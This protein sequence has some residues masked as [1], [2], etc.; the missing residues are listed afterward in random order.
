MDK[1]KAKAY[2]YIRF[3]SPDQA[4][5]DSYRR[6]RKAAED[7]C[8]D[9]DLEFVDSKEYLFFDKGKSAYKG[10]HLDDTGELAR[11]LRFVKDGTVPTGSY[12]LIENLDRLSR[13]KLR[14]ALPR[15]LDL[16][17]SQIKVAT[18]SDGRCYDENYN[19]LDLIIS[20]VQMS[21]AHDESF[22][23]SQRVHQAW[24]KKQDKA[25]ADK[26]PLGAACPSWLTVQD[27]QYVPIPERVEVVRKIFNL[28]KEGYGQRLICNKLNDE[29]VPVFGTDKRN[30]SGKWGTS[31]IN[32]I[33]NNKA[34]IGEYQPTNL[35]EGVRKPVGEPVKD[36]FP[37]VVDEELWYSAHSERQQRAIHKTTKPAKI[38]N[39]WQGIIKCANCGNAYHLINKGE[40]SRGGRYLRCFGTTKREC[41]TPLIRWDV[42]ELVFKELLTKVDSLPL[43]KDSTGAIQQQLTVVDGKLTEVNERL[44][45]IKD[46]MLSLGG[47]MPAA[48]VEVLV[49]L[50]EQQ[51]EL[52]QQKNS[53]YQEMQREKIIDKDEFLN[54]VDLVSYEGRFKANRL[55]KHLGVNVSV[56][57]MK[58]R[59]IFVVF[60][61]GEKP[62]LLIHYDK[63]RGIHIGPMGTDMMKLCMDQGDF[64]AF[65]RAK[66]DSPEEKWPALKRSLSKAYFEG[67]AEVEKILKE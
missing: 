20:I 21:R 7:F 6:Q 60:S 32:K 47:K 48:L 58:D 19:D 55:L 17:N 44:S 49:A 2:S 18:L 1:P 15:F 30:K 57:A 34:V 27:G 22:I 41:K 26:T 4:K 13:E 9:N 24:K 39:V 35:M 52:K 67:M 59:F 16:L 3:S 46:Q 10:K 54:K 38:F 33:L 25:R 37:K 14:D 36:L 28:S 5:G 8:K 31:S 66:K 53:L 23:K 43:V 56:H 12:L 40:G 45:E 29:G 64:D 50:E 42:S 63:K 51:T 65:E 11:F 62:L 61:G